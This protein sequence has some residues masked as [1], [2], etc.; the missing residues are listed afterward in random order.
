MSFDINKG[1]IGVVYHSVY[2]PAK[3]VAKMIFVVFVLI[4]LNVSWVIFCLLSFV[5]RVLIK[6]FV[7]AP[8]LIVAEYKKDSEFKSY[9]E[10]RET[11]EIP[12]FKENAST[13][14]ANK[15]LER[16]NRADSKDYVSAYQR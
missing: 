3:S 7:V 8:I 15:L 9:K 6:I 12:V 10:Y 16:I 2:T 11:H 13:T 14:I 5:P 4:P 1:F